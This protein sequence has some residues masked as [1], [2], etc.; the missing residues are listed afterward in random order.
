MFDRQKIPAFLVP[1]LNGRMVPVDFMLRFL[2]VV[3]V[4]NLMMMMMMV[5]RLM[6]MRTVSVLMIMVVMIMIGAG[7]MHFES[8]AGNAGFLAARDMQMVARQFQSLKLR[9]EPAGIDAQINQRSEEH[10]TADAAEDVE[11]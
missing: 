7:H 2:C 4:A 9:L 8:G 10:V 3:S 11:V 6:L 1:M 5:M